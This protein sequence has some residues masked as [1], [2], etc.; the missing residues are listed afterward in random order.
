MLRLESKDAATSASEVYFSQDMKN[1][2]SSSV[3]IDDQLYGFSGSI[4][5][6]MDFETGE[7]AWR[8]RSVGKGQ[9]I[10][11]DGRLYI[12][13]DDGVV[14]LVEPN[15]AEY[16][17]VSRFEIGSRAYPTWTLPVIA[18]GKLYLRDQDRLYACNVGFQ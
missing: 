11:A 18:D 6:A 14:G 10:H 4:L 9:M 2:Y 12:L 15:P 16:C 3:L 1:H 8:D 5:T 17:K 7:V 13:S